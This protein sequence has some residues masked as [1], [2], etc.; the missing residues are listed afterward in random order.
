MFSFSR[1]EWNYYPSVGFALHT[2]S[3]TLYTLNLYSFRLDSERDT[4]D[5]LI[6]KIVEV[7]AVVTELVEGSLDWGGACQRL[8]PYDGVQAID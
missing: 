4:T 8:P 5:Q 1:I 6:G 3:F 2:P 7:I